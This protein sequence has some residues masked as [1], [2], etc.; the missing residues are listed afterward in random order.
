MIEVLDHSPADLTPVD[1]L[2]LL[3]IAEKANDVTR[4]GFPGWELLAHRM[5]WTG[6]K[7]GGRNAVSTA[8]TRLAERGVDVRVPVTTDKHGRP[9]YAVRGRRTTYRIP[10]FRQGRVGSTSTLEQRVDGTSTQNGAT[11]TEDPERV[12]TASTLESSHT[13]ST[14]TEKGWTSGGAKGG[15]AEGERVDTAS[16]PTLSEPSKNP[17]ASSVQDPIVRHSDDRMP[18]RYGEDP[19]ALPEPLGMIRRSLLATNPDS[20]LD[21]ARSVKNLI[22]EKHRPKFISYYSKIAHGGGFGDYLADV[23]DA[24]A[25]E[26]R[27]VV[28]EKKREAKP[29]EHGEPGGDSLMTAEGKPLCPFCRLGIVDPEP[30]GG[31]DPRV[32]EMVTAWRA[33]ELEAGHKPTTPQL[34]TISQLAARA[35]AGGLYPE[36][37]PAA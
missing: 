13:M 32:V 30:T 22:V 3:A 28:E 25:A 34:I 21:E 2:L 4:E 19:D 37:R 7:D 33:A 10:V 31:T 15:Q 6:G 23:R 1:R 26:R 36:R 16:T 14:L 9:V 27:S 29:C 17:Q 11:S 35:V 24:K 20:T 8:L 5:G 18:P 12:D